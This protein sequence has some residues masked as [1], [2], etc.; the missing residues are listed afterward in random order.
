MATVGLH[1]YWKLNETSGTTAVDIVGGSNGTYNGT[2]T[3]NIPSNGG[4]TGVLFDGATGFMF[5]SPSFSAGT[6]AQSY[7]VLFSIAIPP[8]SAVAYTIFGTN[9]AANA[10]LDALSATSDVVAGD[11]INYNT[12]GSGGNFTGFLAPAG[13]LVHV[14]FT[15]DGAN[16]HCYCNAMLLKSTAA[17]TLGTQTGLTVGA[18]RAGST[19][20]VNFFP[21]VITRMAYYTA[22]L[23]QTTVSAHCAA[24]LG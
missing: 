10:F 12:N 9:S 20:P 24:A 22:A 7:E 5:A 15:Y 1:N 19:T 11:G 13:T 18:V 2:V 17:A 8:A 14:V 6:V 3:L 4:F 23:T 16:A 21:G